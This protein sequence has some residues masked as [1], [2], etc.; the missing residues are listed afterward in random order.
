MWAFGAIAL[1]AI[2]LLL[3][4]LLWNVS[5]KLSEIESL[6][7]SLTVLEIFLAVIAVS[8]FFLIRNAAMS[9]AE[10][11][12]AI[13]AEK[14]AKREMAELAPPIVNRA[15]QEYISLKEQKSGTL[16]ASDSTKRLMQALDM[17]END[18]A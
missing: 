14:V 6:S 10:A 7:V 15:V 9:R 18:D 1:G 5:G 12:A 17:E 4:G 3:L 16:S 11:E 13:V 2:N 8:G